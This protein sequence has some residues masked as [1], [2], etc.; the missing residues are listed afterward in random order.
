V[1]WAMNAEPPPAVG[2]IEP[3]GLAVTH[4]LIEI[5]CASGDL[6]DGPVTN[7]SAQRGHVHLL[8]EVAERGIRC[9][10]TKLQAERLSEHG[11]VADGKA[12]EIPQALA[13]AQNSENSDQQQIP[14]RKPNPAPH[15]CIWD[16][17][18]VSDQVEIGCS[19]VGIGQKEEAIPPTSTHA[20][21]TH[22]R[23][24]DR[25]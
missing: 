11:V 16:R 1:T 2:S 19:G 13:A 18:E 9:R 15:P 7:C 4:Q 14:G 23:A 24:C 25:L 5:R 8:E 20:D 3:Q 22:K 17:P 21:R 10:P 6:G 12:F